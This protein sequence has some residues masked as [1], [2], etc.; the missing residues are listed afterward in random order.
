[1]SKKQVEWTG[2]KTCDF[3]GKECEKDLY[4]A[5]TTWGP[6]ATMCP[7]CFFKHGGS[8]GTGYGQHYR[9]NKQGHYMKVAG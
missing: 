3:C 8:L 4:D 7:D 2:S 9:K 1:M 6:W 5:A